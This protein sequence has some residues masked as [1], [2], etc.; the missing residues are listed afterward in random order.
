[1]WEPENPPPR[2]SP[3]EPIWLTAA[4]VP[5]DREMACLSARALGCILLLFLGVRGGVVPVGSERLRLPALFCG[6]GTAAATP[7][8]QHHRRHA[9]KS[10]STAA[11]CL[12]HAASGGEVVFDRGAL[13]S[14]L[15]TRYSC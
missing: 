14:A 4:L 3:Q 12:T 6:E 11:A 2:P 15:W 5:L 7:W 9:C 1:M 13:S 10:A 8:K